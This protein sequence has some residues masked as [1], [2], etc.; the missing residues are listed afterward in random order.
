MK[1][2]KSILNSKKFE[3]NKLSQNV[4]GGAAPYVAQAKVCRS[5]V[6]HG[7]SDPVSA[8]FEGPY[9]FGDAIID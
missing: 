4:V 9:P 8:A 3:L 5:Y 6:K 7:P 1:K 2:L